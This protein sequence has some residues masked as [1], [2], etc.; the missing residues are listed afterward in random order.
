[1]SE[2]IATRSTDPQT[3]KP[4]VAFSFGPA[5]LWKANPDTLVDLTAQYGVDCAEAY[6]YGSIN[7][8]A[9]R[10][11]IVTVFSTEDIINAVEKAT[12]K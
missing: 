7:M 8:A 2:L 3:L 10:A 9:Q 1:M 6:A 11:G 4:E 12:T 5:V